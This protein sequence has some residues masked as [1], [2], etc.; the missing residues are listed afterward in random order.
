MNEHQILTTIK[1]KIHLKSSPEKVFQFLNSDEGRSKFWVESSQE[2]DG[3]IYFEFPNGYKWVSEIIER[4]TNKKFKIQYIDNSITTFE[5]KDDGKGGSDVF[6]SDENVK[7]EWK[8]DVLPGWVSVLMNLKA[9]LDFGIDL[10]NHDKY[11]TWD[12]SYCD[13]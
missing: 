4:I 5:I 11:K 13:N 2:K 10:R 9:S 6:L 3:K 8:D 1:W 12:E 7:I